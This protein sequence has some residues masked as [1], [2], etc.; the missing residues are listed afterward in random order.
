MR[1]KILD[2]IHE[3]AVGMYEAGVM[4]AVTMR[5]FDELCLPEVKKLTP[6]QIKKLRLREKV[7]QPVFAKYLNVS[8]STAK[9]WETGEK[10]PSGAALRLLQIIQENGLKIIQ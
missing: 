4:D 10:S 8:A 9:K 7:S 1:S 6:K 3:M 5:E 2:S